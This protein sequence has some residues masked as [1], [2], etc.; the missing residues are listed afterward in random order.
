MLAWTLDALIVRR[1][2]G[3]ELLCYFF[4]CQNFDDIYRSRDARYFLSW[5]FLLGR[6][7]RTFRLHGATVNP[8]TPVNCGNTPLASQKARCV[9]AKT[10]LGVSSL[11]APFRKSTWTPSLCHTALFTSKTST[12]S[13][14]TWRG[15]IQTVIS[16][17]AFTALPPITYN[18]PCSGHKVVITPHFQLVPHEVQSVLV[19][20]VSF[21]L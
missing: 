20:V 17:L 6:G 4:R 15:V 11:E 19:Q 2:H 9:S 5:P 13:R 3:I 1:V 16:T 7:R 21:R 18:F 12:R 10:V 14:H 8:L